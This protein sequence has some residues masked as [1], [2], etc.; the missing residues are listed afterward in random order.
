MD[1]WNC[2]YGIIDYFQYQNSELKEKVIIFCIIT[3]EIS[4]NQMNFDVNF[5]PFCIHESL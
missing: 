1:E 5:Q 3:A 2:M 4:N